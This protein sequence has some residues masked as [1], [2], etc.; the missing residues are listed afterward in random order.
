[1]SLK[2]WVPVKEKDLGTKLDAFM[3]IFPNKSRYLDGGHLHRI[4]HPLNGSEFFLAGCRG[5]Y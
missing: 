3:H 5:C 4:F 2:S 1:M